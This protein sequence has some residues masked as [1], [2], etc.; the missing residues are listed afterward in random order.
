MF[1]GGG[2]RGGARGGAGGRKEMPK[3]KPTKKALDITLEDIY[4]GRIV[5]L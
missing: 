3:V 1:F 5:K 4:N 2:G